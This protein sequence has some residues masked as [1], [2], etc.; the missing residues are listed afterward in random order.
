MFKN[1]IDINDLKRS[2]REEVKKEL[3]NELI[4]EKR[5]NHI[6]ILYKPLQPHKVFVKKSNKIL[7]DY[8]ININNPDYR[9][10]LNCVIK[11]SLG[12]KN[13]PKMTKEHIPVALEITKDFCELIK[14]YRRIRRE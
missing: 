3:I 1:I 13:M 2:I 6:T 8:E 12:I 14:K 5:E 11:N 9:N 7:Q 10:A 4:L